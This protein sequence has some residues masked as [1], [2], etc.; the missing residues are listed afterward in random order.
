MLPFLPPTL[1]APLWGVLPM[2]LHEVAVDYGPVGLVCTP[3]VRITS[4]QPSVRWVK[5]HVPAGS[6]GPVSV[7]ILGS[8]PIQMARAAQILSGSGVKVVDINL[9]CPVRRVVR[10]GAGAAL[11]RNPEQLKAL[12]GA[13]RQSTS[14]LLS[15]K[16]RA[17]YATRDTALEVGLLAQAMGIDFVTL[18]PRSREDMYRDVADWNLVGEL[19]QALSIPV[20]GN[21]DVWYAADALRL[22]RAT[23]CDGVMIGRPA[24]R[25]PWIFRQLEQLRNGEPTFEPTGSDV[26]R[27]LQ[28]LADGIRRSTGNG[29]RG[30]L[31]P[32]KEHLGW[33]LR[34]V[35]GGSELLGRAL[36][37]SDLE[38][39]LGFLE[40]ELQGLPAE[41]LD[42]DAQGRDRLE[43]SPDLCERQT[44]L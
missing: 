32:F 15:A 39:V 38:D 34:A 25:N 17:G 21:G 44:V 20:V 42:L 11:L 6:L 14:C 1:L 24:L 19:K 12:L 13:V 43:V 41:V 18:H 40:R 9:G 2:K 30:P 23:G 35:R 10:K 3:F 26:V 5:S 36:R 33:V 7:Q 8:D 4:A 31:A 27:H 28:H 29:R 16:F 22:Q 37:K